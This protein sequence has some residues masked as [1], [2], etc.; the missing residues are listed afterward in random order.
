MGTSPIPKMKF[1]LRGFG[2]EEFHRSAFKQV[3]NMADE[4]L[5]DLRKAH[6]GKLRLPG[7]KAAAVYFGWRVM[8]CAGDAQKSHLKKIRKEVQRQSRKEK[9]PICASTLTVYPGKRIEQGSPL[10]D[11]TF[12]QFKA[13]YVLY[14]KGMLQAENREIKKQ[15]ALLIGYDRELNGEYFATDFWLDILGFAGEVEINARTQKH[16]LAVGLV[17]LI[18]ERYVVEDEDEDEDEG[19]GVSP[20]E[21][22][23]VSG[24]GLYLPWYMETF[25]GSGVPM[26]DPDNLQHAGIY[27]PEQGLDR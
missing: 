25:V 1:D 2:S 23:G 19:F 15:L 18:Q 12:E 20:V 17:E 21:M 27:F 24:T 10:E 26:W 16:P 3:L 7:W 11:P 9:K 14:L 13:A 22:L 5:A 6:D 8:C 4:A